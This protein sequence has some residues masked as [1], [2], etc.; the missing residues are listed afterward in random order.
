MR[1]YPFV[2]GEQYK[3]L[4]DEAR[5]RLNLIYYCDRT[6]SFIHRGTARNSERYLRPIDGIETFNTL[7]DLALS[8]VSNVNVFYFPQFLPLSFI[9][10]HFLPRVMI[11]EASHSLDES[12]REKRSWME[13]P[14]RIPQTQNALCGGHTSIYRPSSAWGESFSLSNKTEE[15]FI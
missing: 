8:R 3:Q 4:V 7:P 12:E 10:S 11:W 1:Q 2:R 13:R 9:F 15:R 5:P 14:F 6:A